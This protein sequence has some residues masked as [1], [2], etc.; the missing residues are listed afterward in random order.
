MVMYRKEVSRRWQ[1]H[2]DIL[3]TAAAAITDL[4]ST[5]KLQQTQQAGT[6]DA[7][8]VCNALRK[9]V[10][11]QETAPPRCAVADLPQA[12]Q[13]QNHSITM[14]NAAADCSGPERQFHVSNAT[15]AMPDYFR[16][17]VTFN[18]QRA[19]CW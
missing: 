3:M 9:R 12:R 11:S 14:K 2:A 4:Y 10:H 18:R 5:L 7:T 19:G 17:A 16:P 6:T 13:A 15:T 8:C 1:A